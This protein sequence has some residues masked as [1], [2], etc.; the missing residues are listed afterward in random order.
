M[1]PSIALSVLAALV[2]ACGGESREDT[3]IDRSEAGVP[4]VAGVWEQRA[5]LPT[6]RSEVASAVLNGRI[7]VIGG[8]LAQGSVS[9]IVEVYDPIVDR[10]QRVASLPAARD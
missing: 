7:Y 3:T 1:R 9:D 8:Y 6:P 5:P 4:R 2:L 10:W